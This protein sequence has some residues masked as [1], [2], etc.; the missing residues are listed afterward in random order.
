MA[1]LSQAV[2]TTRGD[3]PQSNLQHYN[4]ENYQL[5]V[6]GRPPKTVPKSKIEELGAVLTAKAKIPKTITLEELVRNLAKPIEAMLDAGYSYEDISAVFKEQNV[7]I[8][9][10]GLKSWHR[11][12][13]SQP[14]EPA[15]ENLNQTYSLDSTEKPVEEST[16]E[17][18]VEPSASKLSR[19]KV[20]KSQPAEIAETSTSRF[21]SLD[22]SK[23]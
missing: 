14:D 18:T 12:S 23:V 17:S 11:K 3:Y 20:E 5:S 22:R 15:V 8:A 19:K 9:A 13:Q 10:S 21:N 1:Q 7:E 16:E 2:P 4:R 6:M